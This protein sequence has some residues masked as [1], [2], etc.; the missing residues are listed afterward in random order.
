MNPSGANRLPLH[1]SVLMIASLPLKQLLID[2]K[3]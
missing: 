1:M 2:E 3:T